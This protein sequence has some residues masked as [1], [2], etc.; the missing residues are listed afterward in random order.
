M[1]VRLDFWKMK[2]WNRH[3]FFLWYSENMVIA[4]CDTNA[5]ILANES[6]SFL[7]HDES[8]PKCVP[9]IWA[10]YIPNISRIG[11]FGIR[12]DYLEQYYETFCGDLMVDVDAWNQTSQLKYVFNNN[13]TFSLWMI[14]A[15]IYRWQYFWIDFRHKYP[16][17]SDPHDLFVDV[18]LLVCILA[19]L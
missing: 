1:T 3:D 2:P 11:T 7:V 14:S 9:V 18:I 19:H 17:W 16:C 6:S 13:N 15:W 12:T 8:V 10:C 5:F 4:E